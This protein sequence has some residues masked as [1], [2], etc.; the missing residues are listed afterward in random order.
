M[1]HCHASF[2]AKAEPME[3]NVLPS[4]LQEKRP[5]PRDPG[6]T[7]RPSTE[8]NVPGRVGARVRGRAAATG[9]FRVLSR[10]TARATALA[11][12]QTVL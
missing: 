9:D 4:V 6:R 1:K 8:W 5:C 7:A 3:V 11:N 10:Q 12:G 2:T